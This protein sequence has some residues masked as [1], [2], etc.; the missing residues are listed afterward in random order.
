ME[1]RRVIEQLCLLGK[2]VGRGSLPRE[3]RCSEQLMSVPYGSTVTKSRT[4]RK[5][6][7]RHGPRRHTELRRVYVAL[8][9]GFWLTNPRGSVEPR[10]FCLKPGEGRPRDQRERSGS[11]RRS[12]PV[13]Q[14][15]SGTQ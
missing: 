3:S 2:I 8:D 1:Y 12:A 6:R 4:Y 14:R 13:A 9:V 10:G 7:T 15:E 5:E 11:D